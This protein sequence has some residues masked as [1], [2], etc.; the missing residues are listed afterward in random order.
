MDPGF[1][2]C[3]KM[4]TSV[5]FVPVYDLTAAVN[6]LDLEFRNMPEMQPMLEWYFQILHP[7]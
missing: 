6:A 3:A 1:A 4:L 2:E 7:I 5:A